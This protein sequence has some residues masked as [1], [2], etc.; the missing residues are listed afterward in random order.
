MDPTR[1]S[2]RPPRTTS[3]R[4]VA[5]GLLTGRP[6]LELRTTT[7]RTEGL[8]VDAYRDATAKLSA[9]TATDLLSK[10]IAY[11]AQK[12]VVASLMGKTQYEEAETEAGRLE[13]IMCSGKLTCE[14]AQKRAAARLFEIHSTE[15]S[16]IAS[17]RAK[18]ILTSQHM[19]EDGPKNNITSKD[20]QNMLA[21]LIM[22]V[23]KVLDVSAD[24]FDILDGGHITSQEAEG[25]LA[26]CIRCAYDN[27]RELDEDHRDRE[28]VYEVGEYAYSLLAND[29]VG[30]YIAKAQLVEVA[31]CLSHEHS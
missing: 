22:N 27:Y 4:A 16:G 7:L 1:K 29:K 3:A 26:A 19:T 12:T 9:D 11:D 28:K 14:T 5:R 6:L 13:R 10:G 31:V 20:A 2:P 21:A 17:C 23:S 24:A 30:S 15:C 8:A 18:I 25:H